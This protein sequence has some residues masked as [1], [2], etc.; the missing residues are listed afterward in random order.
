MKIIDTI[1]QLSSEN[2]KNN[3]IKK[4]QELYEDAMAY[5]S[6][7]SP[8]EQQEALRELVNEVNN[9]Y[10]ERE[11]IKEKGVQ[12][13]AERHGTDNSIRTFSDVSQGHT[14]DDIAIASTLACSIATLIG[15]MCGNHEFTFDNNLIAMGVAAFSSLTMT[16]V[17]IIA[18][19][20]R[21]LTNL[22]L[23]VEELIN[24]KK[25]EDMYTK[26][27]AGKHIL[28]TYGVDPN[29]LNTLNESQNELND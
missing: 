5:L 23:N 8:E 7:L 21:P 18:R 11:K 6:Q 25:A 2:K 10:N 19:I 28:N 12:I 27:R 9:Y 1:K 15:Y 29:N 17:N 4:Q 16:G 20:T 24:N 22:K 26:F 14:I 3:L 13:E